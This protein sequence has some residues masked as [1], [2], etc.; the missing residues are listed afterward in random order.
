MERASRLALAVGIAL[1]ALGLSGQIAGLA[2]EAALAG[3]VLLSAL[4]MSLLLAGLAVAGVV[5]LGS[6]HPLERLGL[7]RG[8]LPPRVLALLVLGVLTLSFAADGALRHADLRE[9]GT[10][11]KLD[12]TVAGARG[13]SLVASTLFL[14]L[15][16]AV[17]E[18]LFFR[19]LLQRGLEA[20]LGPAL[21]IP[22][23]SLLFAAIHGDAVHGAA[24]FLLGLY[25]GAV[26]HLSGGV[27]AAILCH[28]ANNLA[29][30]G[31]GAFGLGGI[32]LP[33]AGILALLALALAVLWVARRAARGQA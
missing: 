16:P 19:G 28:A 11:G 31:M 32:P 24:A 20:R 14:G 17:G 26:A 25:L 30:V 33:W 27:R 10:L 12:R 2:Q 7:G 5:G 29:A 4:A 3:S 9:R 8:R 22:L 18:E 13:G 1:L 6:P 15:A 23:A 21:A